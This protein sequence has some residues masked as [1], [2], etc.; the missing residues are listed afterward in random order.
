MT[1]ILGPRNHVAYALFNARGGLRGHLI[2]GLIVTLWVASGGM[3]MTMSALDA[4]FDAKRE[5]PFYIQRPLAMLLT[6]I[7]TVLIESG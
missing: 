6:I 1:Q 4:A 5:Y 2:I 7:V 3:S